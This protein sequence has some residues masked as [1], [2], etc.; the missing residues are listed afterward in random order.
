[1]AVFTYVYAKTVSL[2]P[3]P[4]VNALVKHPGFDKDHG[5]LSVN[6]LSFHDDEVKSSDTSPTQL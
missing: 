3:S 2:S 4:T 1:M 6:P 5:A